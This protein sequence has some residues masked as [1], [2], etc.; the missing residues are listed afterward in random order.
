MRTSQCQTHARDSVTSGSPSV[1]SR[2]PSPPSTATLTLAALLILAITS[3][4]SAP[5]QVQQATIHQNLIFSQLDD[6]C[7]S[8]LFAN[9]PLQETDTLVELCVMMLVQKSKALKGREKN[10]RPQVSG[11]SEGLLIPQVHT[12]RDRG[13]SVHDDLQGHTGIQS[14]GFFLYRPRNG[15]RSQE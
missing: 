4:K 9:L 5:P 2:V 15:R 3:C 10:K 1:H 12:R 6:V 8:Y 14:R 7:S 13:V 11:L